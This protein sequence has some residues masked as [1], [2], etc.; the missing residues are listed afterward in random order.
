MEAKK[1]PSLDLVKKSSY[2]FSIGLVI[3]LSIV[4][5][6]FEWESKSSISIPRDTA[7]MFDSMTDVP[8]TDVPKPPIPRMIVNPRIVEVSREFP[9]DSTIRIHDLQEMA[10]LIE[11]PAPI[12]AEESDVPVDFVEFPASPDGGFQGFYRR[13]GAEI[14]YPTQAKRGGIEGRVFVQFIVNRDGSLSDVKVLKGIGGGCDEE[15]VRVIRN[16][17][18]W[19]PAQQG[20]RKVRQRFTLPVIF[21]LRH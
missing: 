1:N 2:F 12:P 16:S 20:G 7:I 17:P 19:N 8:V 21:A 11:V 3:A 9:V 15:A 4:I 13:V 18:A 10:E 5:T 14:E 6:A